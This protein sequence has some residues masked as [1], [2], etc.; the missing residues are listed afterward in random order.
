MFAS[1]QTINKLITQLSPNLTDISK[2]FYYADVYASL[3]KNKARL[4]DCGEN[5]VELQSLT[6]ASTIGE[7]LKTSNT[8]RRMITGKDW[9]NIL[10]IENDK[11]DFD[12]LSRQREILWGWNTVPCPIDWPP[13]TINLKE[14]YAIPQMIWEAFIDKLN[15]KTIVEKLNL[16]K[17]RHLWS[18]YNSFNSH[19]KMQMT[20]K[21][22]LRHAELIGSYHF[23]ISLDNVS[24]GPTFREGIHFSKNVDYLSAKLNNAYSV[25]SENYYEDNVI[26]LEVLSQ[27]HP[28]F[29]PQFFKKVAH[30]SDILE[31]IALADMVHGYAN[32]HKVQTRM[33]YIDQKRQQDAINWLPSSQ[34][35][36]MK[37]ASA[38]AMA[39]SISIK[40]FGGFFFS[41]RNN[42]GT[43]SKNIPSDPIA[44]RDYFDALFN[45]LIHGELHRI[46]AEDKKRSTFTYHDTY[47]SIRQQFHQLITDTN[48]YAQ[49][50]GLQARWH[51]NLFGIE[52][53]KPLSA[54]VASWEPLIQALSIFGIKLKA[55]TS[56]LELKAHGKVIQHC[57]GGYVEQCLRNSSDIIELI[58]SQG[59]QSTLEIVRD[60]NGL[61]LAR[62]HKFYHNSVPLAAH[63]VAAGA[64]IAGLN[65]GMIAANANRL[66]EKPK[67][68]NENPSFNYDAETQEKI[69]TAY[70]SL[71][72]LPARLIA[73][74]YKSMLVKIGFEDQVKNVV[75]TCKRLGKG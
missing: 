34:K 56:D 41:A 42:W 31:V 21:Q 36:P 54:R 68:K 44:T 1:R 46:V 26:P 17:H 67:S 13:Y 18:A 2:R 48:S 8:W 16:K 37:T 10:V 20:S 29:T 73:K 30:V 55:I 59:R 3:P 4:V 32:T 63:K 43:E 57:V 6:S 28:C 53:V 52:S 22:W 71:K 38:I 35:E 33:D 69:Y 40:F 51:R 39:K 19:S 25:L 64:L 24:F 5:R 23:L 75:E 58:D 65:S 62:Q 15:E 45:D 60:N 14:L 50:F 61:F 27:F 49:L 12:V 7:S 66:Q 72:L 74:D 47:H 70:K 9:S 11:I